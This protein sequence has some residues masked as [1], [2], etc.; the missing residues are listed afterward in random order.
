M[1][2]YIDAHV[3]HLRAAGRSTR[4]IIARQKLLKR[5]DVALPYGLVRA[6]P[7]EIEQWLATP[8]W[9]RWTLHTYYMHLFGF[10]TWATA[11]RRPMLSWNPMLDIPRPPVP[12][13]MPDPVTDDQLARSL[14]AA[15]PQ[16]RLIIMLAAYAGLRASEIAQLDRQDFRI[17]RIGD[18]P[19]RA[20]VVREGK[21]GKR[22]AVLPAHSKIWAM[23]KNLPDGPLIRSAAGG[24]VDGHWL[25]VRARRFFDRLKM[26]D[27][28][29][30][31]FRH[32]FVTAAHAVEEDVLVTQHLARHEDPRTTSGYALVTRQMFSTVERLPTFDID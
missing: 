25:A 14:R 4:T 13:S 7:D 19:K 29:L 23:V 8:G 6:A 30:Q 11:G 28:H 20:M 15:C 31:R 10:F 21:G 1:S 26:P 18:V 3:T 9:G 17:L 2:A 27:V 16:Q 5:V 32:W 24:P 22:D 12:K